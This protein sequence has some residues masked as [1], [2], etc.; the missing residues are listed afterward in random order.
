M[1]ADFS[2]ELYRCVLNSEVLS[3]ENQLALF[4]NREIEYFSQNHKSDIRIKR[5]LVFLF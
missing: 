1:L 5:S 3:I 4:S 2:D